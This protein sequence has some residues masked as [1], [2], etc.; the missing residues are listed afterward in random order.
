MGQSAI[1]SQRKDRPDLA[2]VA[3]FEVSRRQAGNQAALAVAD[4]RMNGDDV[5]RAAERR[6]CGRDALGLRLRRRGRERTEKNQAGAQSLLNRHGTMPPLTIE[7][8][9]RKLLGEATIVTSISAVAT[10]AC[11]NLHVAEPSWPQSIHTPAFIVSPF[12]R[13]RM[14]T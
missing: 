2:V 13:V 6:M 7:R 11:T 9:G 10:A 1:R 3:D 8:P 5:Q 4:R 12:F 14:R